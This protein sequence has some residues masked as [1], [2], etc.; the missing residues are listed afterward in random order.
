MSDPDQSFF[1]LGGNSLSAAQVVIRIREEL[2]VEMSITDLVEAPTAGELAARI[3]R[4]KE[5]NLGQAVNPPD[6]E[7]LRRALD[8]LE[9]F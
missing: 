2:G 1:E 8:L 7:T 9:K 5:R 3:G 6:D 4:Q